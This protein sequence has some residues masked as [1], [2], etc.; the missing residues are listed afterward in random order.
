MLAVVKTGGKQYIV[1]PG[2]KIKIEKIEGNVGKEISFK[3]VLLLEKN[4]KIEIG[5][6]IVKGAL[7]SAKIVRQGKG[8]KLIVFKYKPKTRYHVKKGHRQL[9]TEVEITKIENE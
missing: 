1:E 4:K 5:K 2:K 8:D 9:F 6:P 3:S 7:V